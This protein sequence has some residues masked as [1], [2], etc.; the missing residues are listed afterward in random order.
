MASD[1]EKE[2]KLHMKY[3]QG[4]SGSKII[5]ELKLSGVWLEAAGFKAGSKVVIEIKDQE[6]IIKPV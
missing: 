6:L 5:P 2:V 1:R 3:R 4:V